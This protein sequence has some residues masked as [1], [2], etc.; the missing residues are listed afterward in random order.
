MCGLWVGDGGWVVGWVW[1]CGEAVGL[2]GGEG[3]IGD[4]DTPVIFG[5][6]AVHGGGCDLVGAIGGLCEGGKG[7]PAAGCVGLNGECDGCAEWVVGVDAEG[8]VAWLVGGLCGGCFAVEHGAL[9]FFVSEGDEAF[10]IVLV[11]V[12]GLYPV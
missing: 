11:I 5:V 3:A 7:L 9:A 4:G 8:G 2:C 12:F 10:W 6:V 1:L